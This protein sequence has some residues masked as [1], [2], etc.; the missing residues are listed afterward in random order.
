VAATV[1]PWSRKGRRIVLV[2]DDEQVRSAVTDMLVAAGYTVASFATASEALDE[3]GGPQRIDL[4]IADYAMPTIRGDQ[5]A[6]E[7]RSRRPDVPVLFITGYAETES[8]QSER[9]VLRKP[10]HGTTLIAAIEGAMRIAA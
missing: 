10:F 3:I 2:D 7:A 4:F 5:F 9:W 8:L 6:A 1:A